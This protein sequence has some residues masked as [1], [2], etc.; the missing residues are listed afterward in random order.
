MKCF[1]SLRMA[2]EV[3]SIY[4]FFVS[5]KVSVAN[6]RMLPIAIPIPADLPSREVCCYVVRT[7]AC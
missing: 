3:A 6:V 5:Q 7:I 2:V 4:K 1:F